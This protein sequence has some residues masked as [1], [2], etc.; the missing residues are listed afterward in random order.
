[1]KLIYANRLGYYTLLIILLDKLSIDHKYIGEYSKK[2]SNKEDIKYKIENKI[3]K[4]VVYQV[5]LNTD[6][7]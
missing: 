4:V 2:V 6:I 7:K 5:K 1:M 3:D